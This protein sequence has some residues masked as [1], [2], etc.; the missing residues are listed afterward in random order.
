MAIAE[1]GGEIR[2]RAL[3]DLYAGK[4]WVRYLFLKSVNT[5]VGVRAVPETTTSG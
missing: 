3:R 1:F 4:E 5:D 2:A